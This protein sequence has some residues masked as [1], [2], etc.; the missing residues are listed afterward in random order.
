MQFLRI[1]KSQV[2]HMRDLISERLDVA[3]IETGT[4]SVSPE[5]V[6][7]AD[8]VDEAPT[9]DAGADQSVSAGDSMTLSGTGADPD[10]DETLSYAWTQTGVLRWNCRMRHRYRRRSRLRLA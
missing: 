5:P 1:I 9:V 7:V 2:E 10:A 6:D 8:L 4:L 3:L